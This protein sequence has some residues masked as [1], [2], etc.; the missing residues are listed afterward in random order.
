LIS[1]SLTVIYTDILTLGYR[2]LF[3]CFDRLYPTDQW[4]DFFWPSPLQF[5][6]M[7]SYYLLEE[8]LF[9]KIHNLLR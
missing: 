6:T 5:S 1:T 4:S 2:R 7:L 9:I 8:N 3:G